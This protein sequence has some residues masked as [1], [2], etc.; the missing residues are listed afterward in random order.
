MPGSFLNCTAT[1][2]PTDDLKIEEE[3]MMLGIAHNRIHLEGK[4]M[5]RL[6]LGIHSGDS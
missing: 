2:L 1:S 6:E 4:C 5:G 3:S